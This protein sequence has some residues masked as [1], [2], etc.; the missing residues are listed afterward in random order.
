MESSP[1][2][3]QALP[4][5]PKALAASSR[6]AVS[7][8][9]TIVDWVTLGVLAGATVA[10]A[11]SAKRAKRQDVDRL[12]PQAQASRSADP[13][14]A[15]REPGRGRHAETPRQIPARGWKDILKRTAKE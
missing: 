15:A 12:K 3:S 1:L 13:V 14:L 9:S 11:V 7:V 8:A 5:L 6:S 4:R 10:L 2:D